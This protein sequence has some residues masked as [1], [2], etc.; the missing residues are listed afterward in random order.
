MQLRWTLS[1]TLSFLAMGACVYAETQPVAG[2]ESIF[3]RENLAAWCIVPFD[4]KQRGPE[5]RAAMLEN[6]GISKLAYDYRAEHIAQWDE[7]L[8]ALKRHHIALFAWWFPGSLNEDATKALDLFKRH[9]VKPQL[10]ISGNG[11]SLE[12]P[13]PEEQKKRI[14]AEVARIKPIAA[15]AAEIGCQVALYNHGAWFGEPENQLAII[16]ALKAEG[17]NN[18]GLVYNLHHGHS[19]LARLKEL[20]PR[21][22][23]HLLC[24]N[25]N[26]MEEQGDT[27][28][29]KILPLGAGSEDVRVLR[30]IRESGYRGVIGILNHTNEDAEGRLL[31][32]LDGL[33]WLLPQLDG[34]PAGEKPTYRTWKVR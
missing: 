16:E 17:V 18:A 25:L 33:A 15:A 2:G 13:A 20:L 26:G 14:E 1:L 7:E 30:L 29:R 32:N 31:D 22:L 6:M 3:R 8:A 34:K 21:M 5:E 28:G 27:N 24:L 19:H 23:P 9:G 4:A 10:W 11:G 12:A